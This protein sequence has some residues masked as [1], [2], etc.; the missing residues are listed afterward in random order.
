VFPN[1]EAL[2]YGQ[3]RLSYG[4]YYKRVSQLASALLKKGVKSGDVVATLLPNTLPHIEA[5]FGIPACGAVL[6]TINTRLDV[7]TVAYILS[8][9][10]ATMVLVDTQLLPLAQQAFAILQA[11]GQ[12]PPRVI[13]VCDPDAGLAPAGAHLEYEDLLAQGDPN[14]EWIMPKDEWESLALNYTSGTTGRPKGVVYHHRGAY[15]MTMGTPISWGMTRFPRYLTIVPLFHCNNWNHAWMMPALGGTIIC[16][17]DV[18]PKAVYDA[19]TDEGVTHFGGAPIGLNMIVNAPDDVRKPFDHTKPMAM[20]PN[21]CGMM[22]NGMGSRR[23]KK[24]L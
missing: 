6:N 11:E 20:S 15:L 18:T 16:C 21:A 13:E 5:S 24:L 12:T 10:E 1:R 4:A 7:D 19:I 17:R 22:L 23:T 9:G 2:V 3:R 14:F 8:H